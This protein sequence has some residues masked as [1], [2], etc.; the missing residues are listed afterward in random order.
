[1]PENLTSVLIAFRWPEP[2]KAGDVVTPSV[3][4]HGH[5][6]IVEPNRTVWFYWIN[7]CPYAMFAH[8]TRYV[9]I[10]AETGEYEVFH[11]SWP[12]VLNGIEMWPTS[13]EFWD[14]TYWVYSTT[15]EYQEQAR[16]EALSPD[17]SH[18]ENWGKTSAKIDQS[19][20]RILIIESPWDPTGE[21]S[22][23]LMES[24]GE[25]KDE[26]DRGEITLGYLYVKSFIS[27]KNLDAGYRNGDVLKKHSPY[28]PPETSKPN[29][30]LITI[31]FEGDITH[32]GKVNIFDVYKVA[33]AWDTEPGH[34]RWDPEADINRSGRI[35][36]DE[37]YI[38]A[39][40]YGTIFYETL[41]MH[42]PLTPI[43][44]FILHIISGH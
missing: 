7:D 1:M 24:L 13:E 37:I 10:D 30:L 18:L 25:L 26:F 27:G 39:T 20:N 11:E 23:G 15:Y 31:F 5:E 32:D 28:Y 16:G 6:H 44:P 8:D 42:R 2:L 21:F 33:K 4:E 40:M 41:K 35:G 9:L 36:I 29:P 22:S 43:S 12:P 38:M 19:V 17:V 34:P 14:R 3:F